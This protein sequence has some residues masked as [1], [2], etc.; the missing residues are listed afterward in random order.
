MTYF[1]NDAEGYAITNAR[2]LSDLLA[3]ERPSP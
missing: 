2:T 3:V 1:N